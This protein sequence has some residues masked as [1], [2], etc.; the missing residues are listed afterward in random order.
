MQNISLNLQDQSGPFDIIG[1]VHG[2]FEEL[3]HLI[4]RLGYVFDQTSFT[5]GHPEQ[6][7]LIFVGDLV[8]R[9]P[10]SVA[11]LKL[12]MRAV[13]DKKAF[14]V[15]GNHDEKLMRKLKGSDVMIL[16]GLQE[17]LDQLA[18]TTDA[19]KKEVIHFL[20][21]LPCYLI[22]DQG[23]LVI[24]HAGIKEHYI[25]DS[26][27]K[28]RAFCLYG[29]P[30]GQYDE[31]GFPIRYP[32]ANEYQGEAMIVYGHSVIQTPEFINKTINIDTGCV[33]GGELTALRYPE[34]NT[35][36]VKS[37]FNFSVKED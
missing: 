31:Y 20:E 9:G 11:V 26:S 15:L 17:T 12:V 23:K 14:C 36:S 27:K 6:R 16:H 13:E 22:L 28:I 24:A 7:C 30:T 21:N 10:A 35:L 37:S 33:F 18:Q 8:D 25:G 32:W 3:I 34:R 1:D 5:L 2:C 29:Q 4:H 19:F